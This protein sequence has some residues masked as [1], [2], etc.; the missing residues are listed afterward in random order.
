MKRYIVFF[1]NH[2]WEWGGGGKIGKKKI[3]ISK[4]FAY[5]RKIKMKREKKL[6]LVKVIFEQQSE[7][8]T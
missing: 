3:M 6:S 4:G 2:I 8:K 1:K 7:E 5:Q